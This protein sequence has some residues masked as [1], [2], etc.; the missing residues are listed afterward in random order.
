MACLASSVWPKPL[1][2]VPCLSW[3]TAATVFTR[4]ILSKAIA[5]DA[6]E[7]DFYRDKN[8][9]KLKVNESTSRE[10]FKMR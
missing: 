9:Q 4:G 8:Y 10:L 7:K 6:L 3:T 2:L 5:W 1:A